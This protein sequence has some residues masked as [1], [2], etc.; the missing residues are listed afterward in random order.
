MYKQ[1]QMEQAAYQKQQAA[2]MKEMGMDP[3]EFGVSAQ[4]EDP[5]LADLE[6]MLAGDGK[7]KESVKCV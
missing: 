3:A 7:P 1:L 2:L 6:K 4:N 5:E